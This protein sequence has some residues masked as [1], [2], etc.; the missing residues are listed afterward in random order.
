MKLKNQ[1][2]LAHKTWEIY[3]A[4]TLKINPSIDISRHQRCRSHPTKVIVFK[5]K[6]IPLFFFF[7]LSTFVMRLLFMFYLLLPPMMI[8]LAD[9]RKVSFLSLTINLLIS[10]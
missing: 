7:Y 9:T 6:S 2:I 10:L 5:I 8:D 4:R 1:T 3:G